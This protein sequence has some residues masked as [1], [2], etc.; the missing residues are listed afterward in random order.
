MV[1]CFDLGH[2][3]RGIHLINPATRNTLDPIYSFNR[4]YRNSIRLPF[5][6]IPGHRLQRFS[7]SKSSFPTHNSCS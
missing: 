1:R 7:I 4:L 6:K 5:I 2:H 3:R